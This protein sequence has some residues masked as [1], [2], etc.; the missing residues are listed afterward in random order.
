MALAVKN[1]PAN[2]GDAGDAASAPG[3]RRAPGG[4]HG[5]PLQPSRLEH[6]MDRGAWP[7]VV[8]DVAKSW[9]Q[10]STHTH[11]TTPW[12]TCVPYR[13]MEETLNPV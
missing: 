9:I 11:N 8:H 5:N 6:S 10:L 7:A 13:D 4:G 2:A 3:L 1:L 12:K